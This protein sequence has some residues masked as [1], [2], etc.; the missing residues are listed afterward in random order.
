MSLGKLGINFRKVWGMFRLC[1][2]YVSNQLKKSN[3]TLLLIKE[4]E[5]TLWK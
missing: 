2:E 5:V 3:V 4:M 1:L